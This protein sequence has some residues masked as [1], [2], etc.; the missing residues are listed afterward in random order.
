MPMKTAEEQRNYQLQWVLSRRLD[1]IAENGP[2]KKCGSLDSLEVD[3]IDPSLKSMSPSQIW[4][5]TKSERDKELKKCQVLCK[6]CH[7]AKT[8]T[9][10][11]HAQCGS[12]SKYRAGC[13]CDSCRKEHVRV[14]N[15]WRW[16]KGLRKKRILEDDL[17]G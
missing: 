7:L 6:P 16:R 1:W 13:R 8:L 4:G 14:N 11:K 3:H 15:E 17:V 2:C 9:E 10:R 12:D 5:R